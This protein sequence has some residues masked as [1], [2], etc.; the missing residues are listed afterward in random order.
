M[1][2]KKTL[3]Q[4][5]KFVEVN[6]ADL[7]VK[8]EADLKEYIEAAKQ[9]WDKLKKESE[10]NPIYQPDL[11][12]K[13]IRLSHRG[14]KKNI[15]SGANTKKWRLFPKLR[16]LIEESKKIRTS[17]IVGDKIKQ[18]YV[19]AHWCE[20]NAVLDGEPL[21]VGFTLLE[22][23]DGNLFYNLT[24][25]IEKKELHSILPDSK[26]RGL[27]EQL[28]QKKIGNF[29]DNVNLKILS[30]KNFS[31]RGSITFGEEG[32]AVIAF[33][34]FSDFSTAPHELFHLFRKEI[35]ET[36]S[37]A[38]ASVE[39]KQMWQDICDFVGAKPGEKWTAEQEE[40]FALAGERYL[41]EG[42]APS[43]ELHTV[44]EKLKE[45][46]LKL[47]QAVTN[48]GVEISPK[49]RKVFDDMLYSWRVKSSSSY[50]LC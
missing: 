27:E 49:M 14:W 2:P 29:E 12:D 5:E 21:S 9:F 32:K 10:T 22:D 23:K 39:G 11:K 31:P 44:F 3:W 48:V 30:E 36:A 4:N 46:F 15:S 13:P 43:E 16:S 19:R 42:K 6:S 26:T 28:F 35:E 40:K 8:A 45:W 17:E 24:S 37:L 50:A 38:N 1:D 20:V 7:G 47:Y 18:G 25:G 41:A 34:R 33:F